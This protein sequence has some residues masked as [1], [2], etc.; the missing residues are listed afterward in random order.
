MEVKIDHDVQ[1][2]AE[3]MQ[4]N[5]PTAK[6]A[7]VANRLSQIAS[8]LWGHFE[9]DDVEGLQLKQPFIPEPLDNGD[10]PKPLT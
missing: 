6:L 4:R 8:I 9:P 5:I 10:D 7:G 3:F 2:V 1:V